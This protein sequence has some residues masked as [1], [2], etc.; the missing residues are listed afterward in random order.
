MSTTSTSFRKTTNA[1]KKSVSFLKNNFEMAELRANRKNNL[2]PLRPQSTKALEDLVQCPICLETYQSPKMLPCQHTFCLSCLQHHVVGVESQS[3]EVVLKCPSCKFELTVDGYDG[4]EKLPENFYIN[5][6]LKVLESSVEPQT[7]YA[8]KPDI[9]CVKCETISDFDGTKCQHCKQIFCKVCWSKH[10]NELEENL[11][12]MLKQ[13]EDGE[14]RMNYKMEEM[15]RRNDQLVVTVKEHAENKVLEIKKKEVKALEQIEK[16]RV[17]ETEASSITFT[18]LQD[19]KAKLK[20]VNFKVLDEN[21]Q[22]SLFMSL[23]RNIST[24]LEE[25][26]QWG[27]CRTVFDPETFRLEED[28]EGLNPEVD[29]SILNLKINPDPFE[30]I[31][32]LTKHYK[33]RSFHPKVYTNKFPRLTGVSISPWSHH[34]YIAAPDSKS[35]VIMNRQKNKLIGRLTSPDILCPRA[36]TFSKQKKEIYVSDKWKHCVHIFSSN[37]EYVRNICTKGTGSGRL[38]SPEGIAITEDD[39]LLVCDTGNDR[40]VMMDDKGKEIRSIGWNEKRTILNMPTSVAITHDNKIV[41]ADNGNHR[42]KVFNFNG[43]LLLEFG[44]LGREKRQFRSA[45]VVAVDSLG[46]I[47]VGDAGN[48]RIQIFDSNGNLVRIFGGLG[49]G[50]GKF[51]WISGL[52]I[53]SQLE[54]IVTDHK[55]R[56][57]Q[58]F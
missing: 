14:I 31:E 30:S 32:S 20:S 29:D 11:K 19:L 55:N 22:V 6:L 43:D 53:T 39:E 46:F 16:L 41:V 9:R 12:D 8:G 52:A 57:L 38:T 13:L 33:A 51:K 50:Q 54:V 35:I 47:W 58:I 1:V 5:S 21:Q 25:V 23:H 17:E 10:M 37:G 3:K 7:P 24:A 48:G 18:K 49:E 56:S 42:I 44:S 26:S 28:N 2:E 4:I 34:Y 45:E 15:T 36:I 40:V 27:E